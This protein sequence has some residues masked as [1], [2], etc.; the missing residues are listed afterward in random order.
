MLAGG[1]TNNTLSLLSKSKGCTRPRAMIHTLT[2]TSSQG[3][4]KIPVIQWYDDSMQGH[5]LRTSQHS[6]HGP[7]FDTCGYTTPTNA[8]S[9]MHARAWK[10]CGVLQ[11]LWLHFAIGIRSNLLLLCRGS[12]SFSVLPFLIYTFCISFYME[13]RESQINPYGCDRCFLMFFFFFF[14]EPPDIHQ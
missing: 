8:P 2:P 1:S 14:I 9:L 13:K 10:M 7:A 4:Q 6:W 12:Q 11:W 5:R 3:T